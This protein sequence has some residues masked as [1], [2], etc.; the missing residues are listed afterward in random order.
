[1]AQCQAWD[2]ICR[3]VTS[4]SK[5]ISKLC[6][7]GVCIQCLFRLMCTFENVGAHSMYHFLPNFWRNGQGLENS[8][9]FVWEGVAVLF[10]PCP[11]NIKKDKNKDSKKDMSFLSLIFPYFCP[12]C[13]F[14]TFC[15]FCHFCIFCTFCTSCTLCSTVYLL[16]CSR[17]RGMTG[18]PTG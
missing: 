1:M 11:R 15:P 7:N 17:T 13:P 4:C 2:C 9:N 5:Y 14:C 6:R 18:S 16:S 12:F 3:S 8:F 10:V